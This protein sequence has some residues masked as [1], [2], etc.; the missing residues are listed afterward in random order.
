MSVPP[1][2]LTVQ[3]ADPM[4]ER[5]ASVDA[6]AGTPVTFH[7]CIDDCCPPAD[8]HVAGAAGQVVAR[9]GS[10][11]L[12]N[13]SSVVTV[14]VWCL[15]DPQN[16]S[17]VPPG[18]SVSPPFDLA[19]VT[20]AA[21]H[22]LTVFGPNLVPVP[23][24]HCVAETPVAWGLDPTSRRHAVMIELV[25]RRLAG[26]LAAPAPTDRE[27]GGKLGMSPRTVQ[28]HLRGL[29]EALRIAAPLDRRPGWAREALVRFAITHT[30]IPRRGDS[31][32]W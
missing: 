12:T 8:L 10:W 17:R 19:G 16:A 2:V 6:P 23:K 1:H 9:E 4:K 24:R 7:G 20:G 31:T 26:D 21:G 22:V 15:D 25:R 18:I 3:H 11:S 32:P 29:T 28:E 30:Y 13:L 14:T 27:I 5:T